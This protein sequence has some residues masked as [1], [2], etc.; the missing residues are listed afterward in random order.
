MQP[1]SQALQEYPEQARPYADI[2]TLLQAP[3][4]RYTVQMWTRLGHAPAIGP[5]PRR[6]LQDHIFKT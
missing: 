3:A 5:S 4:P 1:L 6:S 2:H